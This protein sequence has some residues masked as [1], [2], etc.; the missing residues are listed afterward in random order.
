M[1][2]GL[3][4]RRANEDA[5]P[6]PGAPL[7]LPDLQDLLLDGLELIARDDALLLKPGDELQLALQVVRPEGL[8][9]QLR[10]LGLVLR[11][12]EE[13]L[14]VEVRQVAEL[15]GKVAHAPLGEVLDHR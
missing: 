10:F 13:R 5:I 1:R 12:R 4:P 2:L 7:L 11:S 9:E 14:L 6:P 15:I 3:P 8:F